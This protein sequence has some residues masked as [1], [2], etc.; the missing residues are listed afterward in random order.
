[1]DLICVAITCVQFSVQLAC[2]RSN[3]FSVFD[4][5]K[6]CMLFSD[7]M[8]REIQPKAERLALLDTMLADFQRAF[9]SLH[10]EL[11]LDR[12][13]I[14]AQAILLDGKRCVLIYGG[15]ALHPR[16]AENSLTFV[17]L[18]EAGHHLAVGPRLPFNLSL[19]CDCVADHWAAGEGSEILH[20]M[21]GR[22]LQ[23]GK[24]LDELEYLMN[25]GQESEL[26]HPEDQ[27]S[28]CRNHKWALRK[29]GLETPQVQFS[30]RTCEL[31]RP[32]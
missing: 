9:P 25:A 8:S 12:K 5:K 30:I 7:F 17:F 4:Q 22:R 14:N 23:I 21:S 1:M 28:N 31:M 2:E 20:R 26:H 27:I 24:A 13:V 16:L 19:A 32:N 18:H 29:M 6:V 3:L 11:R 10:F 15:L